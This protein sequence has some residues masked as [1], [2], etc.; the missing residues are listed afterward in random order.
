MSLQLKFT[1]MS[2]WL[3]PVDRVELCGGMQYCTGIPPPGTRVARGYDVEIDQDDGTV[4]QTVAFYKGDVQPETDSSSSS[5]RV[6]RFSYLLKFE[7]GSV[8]RIPANGRSKWLPA[9]AFDAE[10]TWEQLCNTPILDRVFQLRKFVAAGKSV[11][12][13]T[14]RISGSPFRKVDLWPHTFDARFAEHAMWRAIIKV[15]G[16]PESDALHAPILESFSLSTLWLTPEEHDVLKPGTLP[17]CPKYNDLFIQALDRLYKAH[18]AAFAVWEE[19]YT[20][21]DETYQRA[22]QQ[23]TKRRL[24]AAEIASENTERERLHRSYALVTDLPAAVAELQGS[25]CLPRKVADAWTKFK[26]TM[27]ALVAKEG[28]DRAKYNKLVRN[29]ESE[30]KQAKKKKENNKRKNPEEK[31]GDNNNRKKSARVAR[32][33]TAADDQARGCSEV[34]D[35]KQV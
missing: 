25:K 1:N 3:A 12:I 24:F 17:W 13:P 23:K 31:N 19:I 22:V 11:Y 10:E 8:D 27:R 32:H 28:V 33:T 14:T 2:D 16:V 7:D 4:L 9:S 21:R 15:P 20:H 34:D 5:S 30:K 26:T 35:E 18:S 6:R 29:D